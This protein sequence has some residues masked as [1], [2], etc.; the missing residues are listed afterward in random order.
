ML[1]QIKTMGLHISSNL[2]TDFIARLPSQTPRIHSEFT[3]CT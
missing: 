1:E 2:E 3:R